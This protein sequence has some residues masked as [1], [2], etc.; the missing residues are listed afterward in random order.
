MRVVSEGI[1]MGQTILGRTPDRY[2]SEDWLDR[3]SV[4]VCTSVDGEGVK[5]LYLDTLRLAGQ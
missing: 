1:A 2:A 5:K 3:P 4:R